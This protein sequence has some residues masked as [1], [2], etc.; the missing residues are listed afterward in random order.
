[1]LV[2][3]KSADCMRGARHIRAR[4]LYNKPAVSVSKST[5]VRQS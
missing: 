1:M 2:L 4:G 5:E 3:D